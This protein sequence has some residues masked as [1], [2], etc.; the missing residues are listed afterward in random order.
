MSATDNRTNG[1]TMCPVPDTRSEI[2]K[3][4]DKAYQ[5]GFI[6]CKALAERMAGLFTP[7]E[8][9]AELDKYINEKFP[10][11]MKQQTAQP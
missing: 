11:H 8:I 5:Q 6:H 2:E 9:S 1:Q 10:D 3:L 4:Y 7:A